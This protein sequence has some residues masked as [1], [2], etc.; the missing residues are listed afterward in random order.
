MSYKDHA[1]KEFIIAGWMDKE[2]KFKDDMQKL[3]CEQVLELLTLFSDHGHSGSTFGYALN[4]FDKLARFKLLTPLTG[5][6]SEWGEACCG[7]S[8]QNNRLSSVFKDKDGRAYDLDGYTHWEWYKND[9]GELSKT[10]FHRGGNG[11]KFYIKFPYT[12]KEPILVFCPTDEFPN[13]EI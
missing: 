8:S 12:Q 1:I 4:M 11:N 5:E 6:D 10:H 7:D 3:M 13:E 9:K 2:G